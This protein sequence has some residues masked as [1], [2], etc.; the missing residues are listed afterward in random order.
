M[1]RALIEAGVE[2]AIGM[3]YN[4]LSHT[5]DLFMESF[6]NSFLQHSSA[7]A[8]MTVARQTLINSPFRFTNFGTQL[9]LEDHVVPIFHCNSEL[10]EEFGDF[11]LEN[12]V[13]S[14]LVASLLPKTP[15][16]L[17]REE[18]I[19][20][21]EYWLAPPKPLNV[22][23]KGMP[24]IGK[25]ALLKHLVH[26]WSRTGLTDH[27]IYISL[28]DAQFS[29]LT[30]DTFL[31]GLCKSSG[32][33]L[34]LVDTSKL[35]VELNSKS[36]L[37]IVDS[38]ESVRWSATKDNQTSKVQI[39]RFL[40]KLRQ[41]PILCASRSEV[42]WLQGLVQATFELQPLTKLDAVDFG[43]QLIAYSPGI[44]EPD[45]LM[46]D[47]LVDM[48][49]GNP[50][51]I[52]LMMTDLSA[53]L[54]KEPVASVQDYLE[55]LIDYKPLYIEQK[56]SMDDEGDRCVKEV[57]KLIEKLKLP[58]KPES[59]WPW[60]LTR[61]LR[62]I[63]QVSQQQLKPANKGCWKTRD[64]LGLRICLSLMGFWR[65]LPINY[66]YYF[67]V[68][69]CLDVARE[70]LS[71]DKLEKF[72]GVVLE[73]VD[74]QSDS[75]FLRRLEWWMSDNPQD[76]H[77]CY[78][79]KIC[80]EIA[81]SA[82]RWIDAL[83]KSDLAAFITPD[84][85]NS[86]YLHVNPVLTLVARSFL[87]RI[88]FCP[89]CFTDSVDLA[90]TAFYFELCA[91]QS[92]AKRTDH[93]I[94]DATA[95]FRLMDEN[96]VTYLPVASSFRR[97]N[98]SNTPSRF[99]IC[100]LVLVSAGN[101]LLKSL[102]AERIVDSLIEIA[103][104]EIRRIRSTFWM[105][106][107]NCYNEDSQN[108][109]Q[110]QNEWQLC[111]TLEDCL[112]TILPVAITR[113]NHVARSD[114][115][116]HQTWGILVDRPM[117]PLYRKVRLKSREMWM[118]E[119]QHTTAMMKINKDT[120]SVSTQE[121]EALRQA[122][123]TKLAAAGVKLI[124]PPPTLSTAQSMQD[125]IYD[126]ERSGIFVPDPVSRRFHEL[127]HPFEQWGPAETI[128][129][130]QVRK[131]LADLQDL[132]MAETEGLNRLWW[133]RKI[134]GRMADLNDSLGDYIRAY[135]QKELKEMV[136]K[137]M[138]PEVVKRTRQWEAQWED[139][140]LKYHT[141]NS[142]PRSY[143]SYRQKV[144]EALVIERFGLEKAQKDQPPDALDILARQ[145]HIAFLL[146]DIFRH[147]EAI[148]ILQ[149]VISGRRAIFR[150]EDE[151]VLDPT[152][153][154]VKV[155]CRAMRPDEG[156]P[157]A[158]T[159]LANA[160]EGE[161]S[162]QNKR[163]FILNTR[164]LLAE[165][166]YVK[167]FR[168]RQHRGEQWLHD[169]L[170]EA[171][172]H[173]EAARAVREDLYGAHDVSVVWMLIWLAR[174]GIEQTRHEHAISLTEQ[175]I[176]IRRAVLPEPVANRDAELMTAQ[177]IL[178]QARFWNGQVEGAEALLVDLIPRLLE[179]LSADHPD[180]LGAVAKLGFL[181]ESKG[182]VREARVLAKRWFVGLRKMGLLKEGEAG[183]SFG[184]KG[185]GDLEG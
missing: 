22:L 15:V 27:I 136:E 8:A 172:S 121:L 69:V 74:I 6:Y 24:G 167:A 144:E 93:F 123:A 32:L 40:S 179:R 155:Y 134:H 103:V 112:I 152:Y 86:K 84:A 2:V 168:N 97:T 81:D 48:A 160:A 46:F 94:S 3:S 30:F 120:S 7:F 35:A 26:W 44:N 122:H 98:F 23:M 85:T 64:G 102:L 162:S 96:F 133:R 137:R 125:Y 101:D 127:A 66:E 56:P 117:R 33:A 50:L 16:L 83:L 25:T 76:I 106:D 57:I 163:L 31:H 147:D 52:K 113:C 104:V 42:P 177:H 148:P 59:M 131:N 158:Q 116:Y 100:K 20:R 43:R 118:A 92:Y 126:A 108:E 119:L 14:P 151:G 166:L 5:A 61:L 60:N 49:S 4:V 124:Q 99:I 47:Q 58:N 132:L 161:S 54:E 88:E 71:F 79:I 17:G 135:E 149:T 95:Q 180:T 75:L 139:Y 115:Y 45:D 55:A 109:Q 129:T 34:D 150:V 41:C 13:Q 176:A 36:A 89:S 143:A 182:E 159:L 170:Q 68:L 12:K 138:N 183:F 169:L 18:T 67:C 53:Y 80:L 38:M 107:L 153:D 65:R 184:L 105:S 142:A 90:L 110:N 173:F 21:L 73:L 178:A 29:K 181:Y 165:M 154:L 185:L 63:F 51:G 175:A 141:A 70:T 145:R 128:P 174:V 130:E 171:Q 37:V 91:E 28:A 9:H 111:C 164:I 114:E 82:C 39:R 78:C 11:D 140:R 10:L 1:A 19:L 157:L 77:L 87:D 72:Q 62:D 156:I 146:A